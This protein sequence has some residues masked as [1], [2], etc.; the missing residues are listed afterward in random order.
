MCSHAE[1]GSTEATGNY[2][3]TEGYQTK[4]SG[5]C[6]HAEGSASVASSSYSHVEGYGTTTSN[7][8]EHSQGYFNVSNKNSDTF[9]DAGNT[10]HSIGIGG[11][12]ATRK[13]A[14]EVMQNGDYYILG[15]GNYN[16]ITIEG[17]SS[18]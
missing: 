10:I 18:V 17:A 2:S 7:L 3:H 1:G 8:A 16:G 9:G 15:I 5:E 4:A 6:S 14:Q 11:N 12:N 13:N